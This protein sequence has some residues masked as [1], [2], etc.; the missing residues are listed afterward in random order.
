MAGACAAQAPIRAT[1]D[2]S[3]HLRA[4]DGFGVNYVER[5]QTRDYK[6]DPQEYGGFSLLSEPERQQILDLIFGPDG[7]R[8]GLLKMF[9]DPHHQGATKTDQFDHTTTT[10]WIHYFAKEGLKKT[11]ARGGDLTIIS[12]LYGPPGW[13]TKQRFLRGRDLD[14]AHKR[15]LARYIIEP[16]YYFYKQVACAGQP[17]MAVAHVV[18]TDT[19]VG[20]IAFA[21]A[22]TK[23][24]D[25]FVVLNL[26]KIPKPLAIRV[27]GSSAPAF[28]AWRTSPEER[29]APLGD[30]AV[31]G[32]H[33]RYTAPAGSV[34]TFFEKQ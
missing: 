19:E 30:R 17:G 15:D 2:F 12:T 4:W 20:L 32:G 27:L 34:T 26:A 22:K 16:G 1:V 3:Q 9:L 23:H 10:R 5:A 24:Q 14:P 6:A 33:L 21:R 11:R 28:T 25:A 7:L 18:S 31:E 13:M 29:Y 8:P